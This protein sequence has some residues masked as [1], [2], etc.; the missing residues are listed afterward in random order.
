[1]RKVLVYP[2]ASDCCQATPEAFYPQVLTLPLEYNVSY[3]GY[4]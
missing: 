1:L 4:D 2:P 3:L